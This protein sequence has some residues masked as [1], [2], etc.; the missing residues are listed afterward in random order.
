MA[1]QGLDEGD[2]DDDAEDEED[3]YQPKKYEY[4]A[5]NPF[6]DL[7]KHSPLI[8][9][10]FEFGPSCIPLSTVGMILNYTGN[11][12]LHF[13]HTVLGRRIF[14]PSHR[15]V[16]VQLMQNG[17]I[18]TTAMRKEISIVLND[19]KEQKA[20]AAQPTAADASAAAGTTPEGND[21]E[22]CPPDASASALSGGDIPTAEA[23]EPFKIVNHGEV[24][25]TFRSKAIVLSNGGQQSLHP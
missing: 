18:I 22:T 1:N 7:Y 4:V 10:S 20:I 25:V 15:V 21:T 19:G 3:V 24:Q 6:K 23:N 9:M 8:Q 13:I 17:D 2:S 5:L 16:S 14:F 12:L 11:H